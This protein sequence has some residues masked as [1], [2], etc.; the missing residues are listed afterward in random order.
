MPQLNDVQSRL[1]ATQ[2]QQV[3]S[4][5]SPDEVSAAVAQAIACETS[6]C[7]AGS[8]HSMGGQQFLDGGISLSS[9]SLTGVGPLDPEEGTVWVQ[10]GVTWPRLVEWLQRHEGNSNPALS[11][12][13]KQ[14]GADEL[15]LGGALSSNI[16]GQSAGQEANCR[17]HRRLPHHAG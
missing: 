5:S 9:S 13:Q 8:L 11:I 17:G 4:P 6:L 3:L 14:T 16:H 2:V 10:S 1:N 15:T 7:P 12:I